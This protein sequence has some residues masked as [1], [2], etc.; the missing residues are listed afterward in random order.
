M[1]RRCQQ[2]FFQNLYK[3]PLQKYKKTANQTLKMSQNCQT[4]HLCQKYHFSRIVGATVKQVSSSHKGNSCL[5]PVINS[6]CIIRRSAELGPLKKGLIDQKHSAVKVILN[7][8]YCKIVS[9]HFSCICKYRIC[10]NVHVNWNHLSIT[11]S[12]KFSVK[13]FYNSSYPIGQH[14]QQG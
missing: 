4:W 12:V 11:K 14:A 13:R 9:N 10:C 8:L 7:M 3:L 1:K 5:L 2:T 6:L